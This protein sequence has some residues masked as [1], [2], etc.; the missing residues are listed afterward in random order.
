MNKIKL[1]LISVLLS[2]IMCFPSYAAWNNDPG[3][4]CT[5]TNSWK[6]GNVTVVQIDGYHGQACD[7]TWKN[8]MSFALMAY[9]AKY[10]PPSSYYLDGYKNF[11][12]SNP[13]ILQ[14]G[15][16]AN[17]YP[18]GYVTT[19]GK[20][21]DAFI[22]GYQPAPTGSII[23]GTKYTPAS[24]N[25][26]VI[27]PGDA[28][29]A[30]PYTSMTVTGCWYANQHFSFQFRFTDLHPAITRI[31]IGYVV[32]NSWHFMIDENPADQICIINHNGVLQHDASNHWW[33]CSSCLLNYGTAPHTSNTWRY[34]VN[35][36]LG[37]ELY[38]L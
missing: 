5:S 4:M 11:G 12:M 36:L 10:E 18:I 7:G 13:Y 30:K 27:M 17:A 34:D 32:N 2:I 31:Q 26:R 37:H 29:R 38:L 33:Y 6:E 21:A 8:Y 23:L 3:T 22:K 25:R 19:N 28:T 14:G 24:Y 15:S 35:N 20:Q 9:D 1:F 16:I